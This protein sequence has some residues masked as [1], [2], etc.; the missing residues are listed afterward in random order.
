MVIALLVLAAP[1][2]VIFILQATPIPCSQASAS[3]SLQETSALKFVA[4]I[5]LFEPKLQ[6]LEKVEQGEY[7]M[8]R[9]AS[10]GLGKKASAK[11]R[12]GIYRDFGLDRLLGKVGSLRGFASTDPQQVTA[13]CARIDDRWDYHVVLSATASVRPDQLV[14]ADG[15]AQLF[16]LRDFPS[17]TRLHD[18]IAW[19]RAMW[20][21]RLLGL[22]DRGWVRCE[23]INV[24]DTYGPDGPSTSHG[25]GGL[26][27][28]PVGA[29]VLTLARGAT[30]RL[31]KLDAHAGRRQKLLYPGVMVIEGFWPG[32]S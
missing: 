9:L 25:T 13:E 29:S 1:T 28:R 15:G 17:Q 20:V 24:L 14:C 21:I 3:V 31:V 5:V 19:Y 26:R 11:L 27:E 8:P 18:A 6:L 4:H 23:E 16:A 30:V 22:P 2:A 12:T 32:Q 10:V 7:V